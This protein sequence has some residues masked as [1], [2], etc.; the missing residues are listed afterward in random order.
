MNCPDQCVSMTTVMNA[1]GHQHIRNWKACAVEERCFSGSLNLGLVNMTIN[2]KCCDTDLCN[3]QKVP[4]TA[5]EVRRTMKGCASR[6]LC[7]V[8]VSSMQASE[9]IV[10]MTCCEG[11]LCNSPEGVKL[12]LLFILGLLLSAILLLFA[13]ML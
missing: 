10:D 12:G 2:A 13:A 5:G 11:D 9:I 1:G 4:A 6:H 3:S 8:P 7:V